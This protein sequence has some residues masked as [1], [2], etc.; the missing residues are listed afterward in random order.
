MDDAIASIDIPGIN[1]LKSGKVREVFDLGEQLLIFATDRISAF[2]YILPTLIPKKGEILTQLSIFWFNATK[3][4]IDNHF[5]TDDVDSYPEAVQEFKD[6]LRGR[7]MLVKKA[8]LIEIECV[9][10]GYIAGSAWTEYEKTGIVGGVAFNNL[11]KGDKLPSTLFTPATKSFSGHDINISFEEM[12]K[13]VPEK[14]AEFVKNKT[15]ELYNFAHN[16]ALERGIVLADTKFEF[17]RLDDKIILIDEI[18]TPDSSRFWDKALYDK[19]RLLIAF[20]KQFVRDYLLSTDW[21]RNSEPPKLPLDIVEKTVERYK[22]AL[23][24]LT[25]S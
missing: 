13:T 10:R 6:V 21:D 9:A 2:D 19:E 5:V 24:R 11:K 12:K 25:H 1:K 16:Y 14:D 18:F 15:I 17:G 7:S 22:E 3:D 23:K 8:E 20:D 4:I